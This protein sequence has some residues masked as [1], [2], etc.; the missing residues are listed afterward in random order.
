MYTD[1]VELALSVQLSVFFI[2]KLGLAHR[3]RQNPRLMGGS[4]VV[5]RHLDHGHVRAKKPPILGGDLLDVHD[6]EIAR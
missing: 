1:S 5:Q 4:L 3:V 6:T 2:H